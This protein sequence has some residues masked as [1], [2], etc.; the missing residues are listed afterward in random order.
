MKTILKILIVGTLAHWQISTLTLAQKQ[1]NIWYF[2]DKAGLD[3]NSGSP[4]ALTDGAMFAGE[5]SAS[6]ADKNTG[7]LLFY[8]EGVSVWNKNHDQMPN[9]FGLLGNINSTQSAL[10]VPFPKSDS[11]YYIFTITDFGSPLNGFSYSVVDMSLDGGLGDVTVKNVLLLSDA[12]EKLTAVKHYNGTDV[13]VLIHQNGTNAYYAYLVTSSGIDPPVISNVGAVFPVVGSVG[14]LKFSPDGS[15]VIVV[16]YASMLDAQLLDFDNQS[17]TLSNPITLSS[18]EALY[19]TS[20]SPNSSK[21]YIAQTKN[22][23]F[24][25]FYIF[26]YDLLAGSPA[27]IVASKIAIDTFPDRPGSLQLAPDCKIYVAMAQ[28][29][30]FL[31]V[32]DEPNAL[33]VA[34]NYMHNAVP[35]GGKTSR[36]GLPN[37][38]ESYFDTAITIIPTAT[39]DTTICFGDSVLLNVSGGITYSWSPQAGLSNPNILNPVASPAITT[40]YTVTITDTGSCGGTA[41]ASTSVTIKVIDCD[42]IFYIPN[43]FSPNGDGDNDILLVRGSGIKNIRFFIYNRWGEKVFQLSI[44]STRDGW[45]GTYK[46]KELNAGVFVW[47]AEVEFEDSNSPGNPGQIYRKGNVMLVR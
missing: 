20:F 26:Q 40:I 11:L 4:V 39:N 32:I 8:T 16:G 47:Y 37:F 27:A 43:A 2:S 15:R 10:M 38:I 1:T 9:G 29:V 3:F 34:C 17:G 25:P 36:L 5:G 24:P 45:D 41:S 12:S 14:Q 23:T 31:G 28:L 46:G 19:G 30:P 33:G 6:I 13:W 42:I 35:L 18:P 21:L 7:A 44:P 22:N